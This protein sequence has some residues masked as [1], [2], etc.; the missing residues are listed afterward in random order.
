MI[1]LFFSP[2]SCTA[3][4]NKLLLFPFLVFIIGAVSLQISPNALCLV[5]SNSTSMKLWLNQHNEKEKLAWSQVWH[6]NW[7][8]YWYFV[9]CT[10]LYSALFFNR[11]KHRKDEKQYG[12]LRIY[13]VPNGSFLNWGKMHRRGKCSF[14]RKKVKPC[15]LI[16]W[17]LL[18]VLVLLMIMKVCLKE[19]Y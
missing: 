5:S 19:E 8:D 2:W 16:S 15:S 12:G 14:I 10:I 6:W 4:G 3:L 1:A 7:D 13:L 17:V 18:F 11:C 9:T